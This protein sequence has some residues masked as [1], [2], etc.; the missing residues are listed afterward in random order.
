VLRSHLSPHLAGQRNIAHGP[1]TKGNN[2]K[3][4]LNRRNSLLL[5][6]IYGLIHYRGNLVKYQYPYLDMPLELIDHRCQYQQ[7]WLAVRGKIW[8]ITY[9]TGIIQEH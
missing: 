2:K 5:S 9:I 1:S 3:E 8:Q 4:E 7:F 6:L